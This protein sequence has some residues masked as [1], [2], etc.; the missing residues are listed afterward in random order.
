MVAN[1]AVGDGHGEE[2]VS[3]TVTAVAVAVILFHA[4]PASAVD[5]VTSA[6]VSSSTVVDK[7]PPTASSPS[8]VVNNSTICQTGTSGALQTSLFGISGGTTTRDFNCELIL[9]ARSVYGMGLKVA[10]IS[11]LCQD[12]RAWNGLWMAGT[13]CPFLG[14][15]GDAAKAKWLSNPDKSP[16]GSIIRVAAKVEADKKEADSTPDPAELEEYGGD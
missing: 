10:G 8:I 1:S 13:P 7:T 4:L 6:T 14:A 12:V 11:I 2:M 5:T 9:L 16:E 15:I 3:K